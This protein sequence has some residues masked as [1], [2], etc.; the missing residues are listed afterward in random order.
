[1]QSPSALVI[2]HSALFRWDGKDYIMVVR[3]GKAVKTAVRPGLKNK[4]FTLVLQGLQAGDRIVIEGAG[5]L[6]EG[7]EV[8]N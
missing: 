1:M 8:A 5:E 2:P 4:E 7:L 6:A 3:E